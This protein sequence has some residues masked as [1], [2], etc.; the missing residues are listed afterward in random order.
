V[1]AKKGARVVLQITP[2]ER[3]ALQLL[4]DGKATHEIADRLRVSESTIEAHL[5]RLFAKMGASTRAEAVAA[6]IRRGLLLP[7][8]YPTFAAELLFRS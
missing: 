5:R 6:A 1:Q 8:S 2:T 7:A 4:A 3:A